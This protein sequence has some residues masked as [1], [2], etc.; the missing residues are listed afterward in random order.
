M[1]SVRSPT[2]H[3]AIRRN[4]GAYPANA[5][6]EAKLS[7][8]WVIWLENYSGAKPPKTEK[9]YIEYGKTGGD[10]DSAPGVD[11]DTFDVAK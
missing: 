7:N 2:Q 11:W 4:S 5:R 9:M 6:P 1:G 3:H 8:I 10:W